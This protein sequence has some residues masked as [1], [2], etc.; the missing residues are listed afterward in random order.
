MGDGNYHDTGSSANI[1]S[2]FTRRPGRAGR[3]SR[4]RGIR[5][6][7]REKYPVHPAVFRKD[8]SIKRSLR[9]LKGRLEAETASNIIS[10]L[11][12]RGTDIQALRGVA[13]AIAGFKA[14]DQAVRA[15][16]VLKR[17]VLRDRQAAVVL[18]AAFI[19]NPLL[20]KARADSLIVF[21]RIYPFIAG[22]EIIES[23]G[24]RDVEDLSDAY[25]TAVSM[26][27]RPD[28]EEVFFAVLNEKMHQAGKTEEKVRILSAW[29]GNLVSLLNRVNRRF[30][31]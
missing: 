23:L 26:F 6:A 30:P 17:A 25:K 28:I 13:E 24:P 18:P 29:A 12:R 5:S 20:L 1:G 16:N 14:G 21:G 10:L 15:L 22:D 19:R 11:A 31:A 27:P 9:Q 4:P 2:N 8:P 7:A 3:P